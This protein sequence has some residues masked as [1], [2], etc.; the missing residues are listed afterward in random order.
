[1]FIVYKTINTHTNEYYIGV[2]KTTSSVFDGYFGS[3]R[4]ILRSVK[5]YGKEYFVR[6]T[7]FEYAD[8]S[9]KLAFLKETELLAETLADPMC[10]NLSQGGRG[11]SNFKGH[12][13]SP[14]T[15]KLLSE[16]SKNRIPRVP[17]EDEKEKARAARLE[18]NNGAW[19]SPESLEK[20]S[21]KSKQVSRKYKRNG[22]PYHQRKQERWE[23]ADYRQKHKERLKLAYSDP[24]VRARH[25]LAMQG[26]HRNKL[27]MINNKTRHRTRIDPSK[28]EEYE[29]KG[30]IEGYKFDAE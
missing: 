13:H 4:R 14:E 2:H 21:E 24:D 12:K 16:K 11:G 10:L 3:G 28:R 1:M 29:G 27:W 8:D 20:I 6:V 23:S 19:F 22:A 17:T 30:Y 25:K 15:K 26:N 7:L 9:E 18:K 5:K